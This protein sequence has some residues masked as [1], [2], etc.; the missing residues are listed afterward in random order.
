ME[1]WIAVIAVEKEC[2]RITKNASIAAEKAV[3]A[4]IDAAETVVLTE[5]RKGFL[6]GSPTG[7]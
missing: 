2:F 4:A 3:L 5:V 6:S 7:D 1:N